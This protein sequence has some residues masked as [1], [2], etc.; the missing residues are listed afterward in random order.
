MLKLVLIIAAAWTFLAG[1][2]QTP[3]S[4]ETQRQR[5]AA[6]PDRAFVLRLEELE[7]RAD[8]A[9]LFSFAGS[10]RN[11]AELKAGLDWLQQRAF[12]GNARDPRYLFTY[13][14]LLDKAQIRDSA[15]TAYLAA[16]LIGRVDAARCAD[17]SAP[18]QKIRLLEAQT[19]ALAKNYWSLSP[20]MRARV[21]DVAVMIEQRK[22]LGAPN[23]WL[24]SGG[25]RDMQT[26][27]EQRIENN[28]PPIQ[29]VQPGSRTFVVDTSAVAPAFLSDEQSAPMRESVRT[30]FRRYYSRGAPN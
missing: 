13:S 22:P 17:L 10:P 20:D 16:V 11:A 1:C 18:G 23:A 14:R 19:A 7:K 26:A 21:L 24:C 25:L 9:P 15:A 4:V 27:L 28:A 12:Y 5:V 3:A 8:L 2:A 30:G 29:P 6:P